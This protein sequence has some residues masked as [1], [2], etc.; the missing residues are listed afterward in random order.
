LP[1]PSPRCRH[2]DAVTQ[3]AE[4]IGNERFESG[5]DFVEVRSAINFL[6]EATWTKMLASYP[7]AELG[8]ALGLVATLVGA[9]KDTVASTYLTRA[10]NTHVGSL[11]LQSLFRGTQNT[12]GGQVG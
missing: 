3:Y 2:L 5:F 1:D 8:H 12:G 10:T 9:A 11:D 7:Q 6:E 4:R